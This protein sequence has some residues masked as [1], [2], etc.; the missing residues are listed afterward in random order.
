MSAPEALRLSVVVCA[1]GAGV[2]LVL[3]AVRTRSYGRRPAFAPSARSARGGVLYA[4]GPGLAP[5]AKESTRSH[6][7]VYALGVAFHLGIFT[8]SILTLWILLADGVGR[9]PHGGAAAVPAILLALGTIGGTGLLVR[10]AGSSLLRGLSH[11][12]DYL[13]NLLTTAFVALAG[14]CLW[15]PAG[16]PALLIAA[17]VLLCYAPLGKIR[18]CLFFFLSRYHLGRHFGRRGTF[19][20]RH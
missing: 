2:T 18:H 20:L 6:P 14:A 9:V 16:E 19:P 7:V 8:A 10:R 17:M 13:A 11:P 1:L 5:T 15:W 12:D 4:L 3:Q